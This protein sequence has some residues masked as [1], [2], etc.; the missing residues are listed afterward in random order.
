MFFSLAQLLRPP[1][2]MMT[3]RVGVLTNYK[4][5]QIKGHKIEKSKIQQSNTV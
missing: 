3:G 1:Y 2:S 5:K 4:S